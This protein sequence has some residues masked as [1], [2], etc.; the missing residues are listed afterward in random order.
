MKSL[1]L[2]FLTS[3]MLNTSEAQR[4]T[5]RVSSEKMLPMDKF[6]FESGEKL[7][8]RVHYGMITAGEAV[9]T[10][11]DRYFNGTDC[12]QI[13]VVGNSSS[14]FDYFIRIRDNW[15]TYLNK[16][17]MQPERFYMNIEE[18]KYRRYEVNDFNR[19]ED[20]VFVTR[21]DKDTKKPSHYW[22]Y[23]VPEG[24]HDMISGSYILRNF[25]YSKLNPGDIIRLDGYFDKELY[26]FK[27]KYVGK[28][29]VKTDFGKVTAIKLMP[30]MPENSLFDGENA[31]SLWLTDDKHKV[32]VKI[33]AKMFV[34]AVEID[35]KGYDLPKNGKL[36]FN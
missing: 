34:G 30:L 2:V 3:L 33:R 17:T 12:F 10:V 16:Q 29:V 21:Y 26:D 25:D 35:I 5:L 14:F 7:S 28:E 1:F 4:D 23:W 6:A 31:I 36:A 11:K 24:A 20:S 32:P 27:I 15:G 13:D 22:K 8:Y 19:Q 9:I 18:G